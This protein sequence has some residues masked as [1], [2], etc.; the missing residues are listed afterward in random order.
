MM[1]LKVYLLIINQILIMI[2][3]KINYSKDNI[4]NLLN[5]IKLS[6]ENLQIL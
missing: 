1:E 6:S 2:N 3:F 5:I 4:Y